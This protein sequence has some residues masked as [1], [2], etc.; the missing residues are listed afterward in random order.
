MNESLLAKECLILIGH[1]P[2]VQFR[3]VDHTNPAGHGGRRQVIDRIP[4]AQTHHK[5]KNPKN[6][7]FQFWQFW[8]CDKVFP[9]RATRLL[10]FLTAHC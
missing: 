10:S 4:L 3:Y 7:S 2:I 6:Q 1:P 5:R 9:C 8:H